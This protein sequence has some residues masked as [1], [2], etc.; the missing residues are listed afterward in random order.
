MD[1]SACANLSYDKEDIQVPQ[2]NVKTPMINNKPAKFLNTQKPLNLHRNKINSP[3]QQTINITKCIS[4]DKRHKIPNDFPPQIYQHVYIPEMDF[5]Q[6]LKYHKEF[7]SLNLSKND[8]FKINCKQNFFKVPK[9]DFRRI[10][11]NTLHNRCQTVLLSKTANEFDKNSRKKIGKGM[12]L[13]R[14][15]LLPQTKAFTNSKMN[16]PDSLLTVNGIIKDI[17]IRKCTSIDF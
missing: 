5:D 12:M 3:D 1:F 11:I 8:N 16:S 4:I 2:R 13:V 14:K 15:E 7:K 6:T 9:I 17:S 10:K